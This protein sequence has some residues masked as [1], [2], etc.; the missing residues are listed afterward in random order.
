VTLLNKTIGLENKR[1][2][3]GEQKRKFQSRGQSSNTLPRFNLS[4]DS[5]FSSGESGGNYSQNSQLQ[6]S[7]QQFQQFSQQ[8]P[9][10][11][12]HHRD[13]SGAPVRNNSP[14]HPNGCFNRGELGHYASICPNRNI[15][16][17]QKDNGRRFGQPL[18]Q[19]RH[20]SA[21]S[22]INKGQWNYVH[23]KVNRV[24]AEQAQ[25]APGMMLD[26]FPVNSVPATVLFDSGASHSFITEQ[27]VAKHN[28]PMSSMTTHLLIGSLNGEM[29]STHVCP[30]VN[31]KIRGIDFQANL[32]VLTSSG[33]DVI[34]GV[35]WLGEC[36][37]IILCAKKSVLLTKPARR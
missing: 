37:G 16:T 8:T 11:P 1:A 12:H 7:T 17:P 21:N 30:Q 14:I 6:R 34:L 9:H 31:L 2:E 4:Q 26:T 33:I 28:I 27:F 36:D 5:Q 13:H 3:L 19:I 24:T 23:G 35:D 29:K 20:E 22:H 18:S 10:V 15:Q 25:D 32:V